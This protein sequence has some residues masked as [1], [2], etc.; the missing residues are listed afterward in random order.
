[1]KYQ[2]DKVIRAADDAQRSAEQREKGDGKDPGLKNGRRGEVDDTDED[3]EDDEDGDEDGASDGSSS[4]TSEDIDD[5]AYRPNIS[6]LKRT[7]TA[8]AAAAAAAKASTAP[9]NTTSRAEPPSA[10]PSSV[11][12]APR[13]TPA[14][15]PSTSAARRDVRKPMRS[16]ILDEFVAAELAPGPTAEPSVGS[17]IVAGGRRSKSAKERE[18][19]RERREYEEANFVR[20]PAEGRSERRKVGGGGGRGGSGYGGEEWKLLGAGADRIERMTRRKEGVGGVLERSRKR[21]L[22]GGE[23][24]EGGKVGERFEKRRKVL[25]RRR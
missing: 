10:R 14:L 8:A 3:E 4:A 24:R 21:R 17:T 15:M 11:Y 18:V 22:D 2:I 9:N 20:L 1:M 6:A 5:L 7:P 23:K 13:M 19:E 25:R 12:K 16:A